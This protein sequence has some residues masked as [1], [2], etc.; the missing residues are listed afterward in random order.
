MNDLL[1]FVL[2]VLLV[3]LS[4]KKG[5]LNTAMRIGGIIG[6]FLMLRFVVV[7]V[8]TKEYF[9]YMPDSRPL[10]PCPP[11]SERG[12][13]NGMDCKSMGDRHGL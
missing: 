2:S 10:P 9:N 5:E 3:G 4:Y 12:D 1:I 7:P 8:L 11:G 6:V 13:K